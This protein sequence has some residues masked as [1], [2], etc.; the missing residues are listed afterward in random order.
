MKKFFKFGKNR[1]ESAEASSKAGSLGSRQGSLSSLVPLT[2]GYEV[3][4]KDLSK[5]HRAA[6][7]GDMIKLLQLVKSTRGT[8][9][10]KENRHVIYHVL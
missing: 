9:V 5:L 2:G 6:W 7:M 3:R 10:D 1:K 8:P 4:E